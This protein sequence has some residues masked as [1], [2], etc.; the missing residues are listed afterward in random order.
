MESCA[1]A[2]DRWV[3]LFA[4]IWFSFYDTHDTSLQ[5]EICKGKRSE[6][7]GTLIFS[8]LFELL[9]GGGFWAHSELSFFYIS[10]TRRVNEEYMSVSIDDYS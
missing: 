8:H 10:F 2:S 6:G 5:R 4:G 9:L 1:R 3:S 7:Q